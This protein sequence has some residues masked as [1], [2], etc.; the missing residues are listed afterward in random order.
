ML[1]KN[2]SDKIN[3]SNAN[4]THKNAKIERNE[5]WFNDAGNSNLGVKCSKNPGLYVNTQG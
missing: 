3:S 2:S 5:K 4:Y 1:T